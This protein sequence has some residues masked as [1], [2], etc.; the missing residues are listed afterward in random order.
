[1]KTW[2]VRETPTQYTYKQLM[3]LYS[4]SLAIEI[5]SCGPAGDYSGGH[6]MGRFKLIVG[7][8]RHGFPVYKQAH[9]GMLGKKGDTLLYRWDFLS[10]N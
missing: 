1:M 6:A 9:S 8:E 7:E 4:F 5:L 2:K 10:G 3:V